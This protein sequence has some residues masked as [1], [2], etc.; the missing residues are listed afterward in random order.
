MKNELK[1]KIDERFDYGFDF[2][3]TA[4]TIPLQKR[5]PFYRKPVWIAALSLIVVGGISLGVGLPLALKK[6]E[7][8]ISTEIRLNQVV[9]PFNTARV[10]LEES[11][12]FAVKRFTSDFYAQLNRTDSLVFSPLSIMT[13]YSMLL[14]GCA[15]ESERQLSEAL[16]IADL[17]SFREETRKMLENT[18]LNTGY[19]LLEIAQSY[20]IDTSFSAS[21]R[22][23]YL[24]CLSENYYAE[25][26]QG[27]LS[28]DAMKASLADWINEK[29][30]DFLDVKA[31]DFKKYG[32]VL[33]LLNTVYL[34]SAWAEGFDEEDDVSGT[35][36]NLDQSKTEEVIYMDKTVRAEYYSDETITLASLPLTDGLKVHFLLPNRGVSASDVLGDRQSVDLLLNQQNLSKTYDG[37]HFRLPQVKVR[38]SIDLAEVWE[39]LGVVDIFDPNNADFGKMVDLKRS[40]DNFYVTQSKHEAGI[41]FTHSG[42]EAAA[43]TIIE[44]GSTSTEPIDRA[45]EFF[46]D[47]PFLYTITDPSGVPLFFGNVSQM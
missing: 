37:V 30:R 9:R 20:W 19:S 42:I 35:F 18:S 2:D 14:E 32:G 13:C 39:Q 16:H 43:Y 26:Y 22:P 21:V 27:N 38:S 33:W 11:Y 8:P 44:E 28:S 10:E 15:G 24:D 3:E 7:K 12:L 1:K 29:T 36:E 41:E 25:A 4:G 45:I 23:S 40:S 34:K 5:K 6:E 17:E 31:E 47:R 46:M